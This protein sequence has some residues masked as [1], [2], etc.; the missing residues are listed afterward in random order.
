MTLGAT[1][2][3]ET[4]GGRRRLIRGGGRIN[5][6][7][8]FRDM[9][10]GAIHSVL[11]SHE[12]QTDLRQPVGA[13]QNRRSLGSAVIVELNEELEETALPFVETHGSDG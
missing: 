10:R 9:L 5:E 1:S 12:A 11:V 2:S 6:Y 7:D 8:P 3:V 13:V 4:R